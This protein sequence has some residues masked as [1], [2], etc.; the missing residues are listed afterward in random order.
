MA[1]TAPVHPNAKKTKTTITNSNGSQSGGYIS[2]G[3]TYYDNGSRI[4]AGSSVT[5]SSGRQW[6]MGSDGKG[7]LTGYAEGSRAVNS[8]SPG[9]GNYNTDYGYSGGSA[10]SYYSDYLDQQ[11]SALREAQRAAEEAARQRT[12]AAIDTNNAYIPQ[13]NQQT[14]KQLQEAYI[15]NQQAKVN[16]PQSLAAMGYTGGP[17]ETS[18]MGLDTNYQNQRNTL[19]T[20]RNNSLDQIRNN[21]NQIQSTGDATLSDLAANYYNNLVSAQ[22]NAQSAAQSQ[23]NWQQ[24]F[25]AQQQA[26]AKSDF[27]NNINAYYNDFKAKINSVENDDDPTNDW[28]IEPLTAARNQK[29]AEIQ[30]AQQQQQMSPSTALQYYKQGLLTKQD[31]INMGFSSYL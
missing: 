3:Q 2:N 15:S 18:L 4:G 30:A 22:Q 14:D 20:S 27:S 17:T 28:Q 21:A 6:T 29:M 25:D 9:S 11:Q 8:N 31:L 12:Q 16:A 23:S 5:D 19:E 13:V 1:W 7:T 26:N 10:N 24:Q